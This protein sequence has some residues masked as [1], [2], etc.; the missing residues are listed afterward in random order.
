MEGLLSFDVIVE[1]AFPR[2][3]T[4]TG[5]LGDYELHTDPEQ[6]TNQIQGHVF[7]YGG[8]L[9]AKLRVC[10]LSNYASNVPLGH[11]P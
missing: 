4:R 5:A 7:S 3:E 9:L 2:G 1:N 11:G 10:M 6:T 8:I